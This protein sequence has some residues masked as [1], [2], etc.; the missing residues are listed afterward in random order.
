MSDGFDEVYLD[1]RRQLRGV[2]E[3]LIAAPA[4]GHRALRG[5]TDQEGL[6]RSVTRRAPARCMPLT[7]SVHGTEGVGMAPT[8]LRRSPDPVDALTSHI[9]EFFQ[10]GRREL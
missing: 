5:G 7:L 3:S 4:H 10:R 1:T 8:A 2:A 6:A 9:A